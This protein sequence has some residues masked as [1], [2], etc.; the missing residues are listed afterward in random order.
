M[1]IRLTASGYS[2]FMGIERRL[3]GP[4]PLELRDA[5]RLGLLR[6]VIFV[7]VFGLLRLL[8]E[9][10]TWIENLPLGSVTS[11]WWIVPIALLGTVVL[12]WEARRGHRHGIFVD[13]QVVN[14]RTGKDSISIPLAMARVVVREDSPDHWESLLTPDM[15]FTRSTF[16]YIEGNGQ[17]IVVTE[18]PD[19]LSSHGLANAVEVALEDARIEA[20]LPNLAVE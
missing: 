9:R 17:Q 4:Q 19:A 1:V 20:G 18:N 11:F 8:K 6:A 2:V 15:K 16:V 13:D 14:M 3:L 7:V 12:L 5:V 10:F